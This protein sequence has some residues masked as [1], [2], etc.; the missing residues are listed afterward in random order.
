M[1]AMSIITIPEYIRKKLRK[2][3]IGAWVDYRR[4][5]IKSEKI[6]DE[7][8]WIR[9][10]P[11][12]NDTNSNVVYDWQVAYQ[13]IKSPRW[14]A[15]QAIIVIE[16]VWPVPIMMLEVYGKGQWLQGAIARVDFY[17][18]YFRFKNIVPERFLKIEKMLMDVARDK[19]R[20]HLVRQTRIDIAFDFNFSFPQ[21]WWKWITPSKLSKRDLRD[22]RNPKTKRYSGFSCLADKNSWY[23]I[24]IYD[25]LVESEDHRKENWYGWQ[26]NL[27]KNWT[28]IEFECY[29]PY[30]SDYE[31]F[32][33]LQFMATRI[34]GSGEWICLGMT[35][36]PPVAF[37]I[38]TA[39]TYFVRY[40]KVH[41]ISPEKLLE[42][43][44]EYH[45]Y[46]EEKKDFYWLIDE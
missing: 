1:E 25:K 2:N 34:I 20:N 5:N 31:D 15:H 4:F 18:W 38:E 30:A 45:K 28:R 14:I 22:H 23:G 6:L 41:W 29:P 19:I 3:I 26:W 40:A 35:W 21:G 16:W 37:K 13:R 8:F 33:L 42:E 10:H 24:R 17:G 32:Q 27:P 7:I 9:Q 12:S 44:A 39:Y 46:I 11:A 36:R 43:L